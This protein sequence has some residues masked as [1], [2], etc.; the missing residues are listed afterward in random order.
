MSL[1]RRQ[2]ER[3]KSNRFTSA[4]QQ[5]CTCITLFVHFF[6]VTARLRRELPNFA[7]YR[8]REHTTTNFSR[9]SLNLNIFLKN[10]NLE[11]LPTLDKVSELWWSR[12]SFKNSLFKWRFRRRRRCGT[13]NSLMSRG[14]P[15]KKLGRPSMS[16]RER[17]GQ[18]CLRS[19]SSGL[20]WLSLNFISPHFIYL[21]V[22]S[23]IYFKVAHAVICWWFSRRGHHNA[24][25]W[26]TLEQY[27][28]HILIG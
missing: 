4:K 3:K 27:V 1:R 24:G 22:Y 10:S 21:F 2:R 8:Q 23:S 6:A 16:L 26:K 18:P 15:A 19:G 13:L 28:R 11:S 20:T 12:C 14:T 17:A 25:C 7:F 9:L 5:L